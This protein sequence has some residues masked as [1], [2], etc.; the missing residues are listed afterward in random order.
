MGVYHSGHS[1]YFI[2]Q[3]GRENA[4]NAA[5]D[6]TSKENSTDSIEIELVLHLIV[7]GEKRLNDEGTSKRIDRE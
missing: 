7:I 6:I 3:F 2:Y 4:A 5:N 1:S